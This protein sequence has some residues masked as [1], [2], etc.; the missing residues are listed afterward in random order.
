MASSTASMQSD[1][2]AASSD[3]VNT[4]HVDPMT[5][6]AAAL[7][8]L[9]ANSNSPARLADF[10]PPTFEGK[11]TENLKAWKEEIQQ[12]SDYM[13]WT[14]L[15][16]VK[17]VPL[18]LQGRAKQVFQELNMDERM[19]WKKITQV[20]DQAFGHDSS[21]QLLTFHNINRMQK[22]GES[23]HVYAHDLLERLDKASITDKRHMSQMFYYGLLPEIKQKVILMDS[24]D[25]ITLEKNAS[26]VQLSL[27]ADDQTASTSDAILNTHTLWQC[28]TAIYTFFP[29]FASQQ[30]VAPRQDFQ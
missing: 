8:N 16:K 17:A 19:I 21:S 27:Q 2:A 20:L 3:S 13:G 30:P 5:Q 24:K 28:P 15:Q 29:S 22:A 23:V 9:S 11:A 4:N 26:I 14:E 10:P 18:L 25:F 7:H 6:L 1:T 12:Y